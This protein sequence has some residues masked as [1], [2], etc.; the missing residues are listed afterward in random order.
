M[1][2]LVELVTGSGIAHA[3]FIYSLVIAVGVIL[4]KKKIFGISLGA[5]FVLFAG[6]LAGHFGLEVSRPFSNS[7]RS[8]V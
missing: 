3:I 7:F 6:I 8:L 4:G 2:W 5:T 1:N